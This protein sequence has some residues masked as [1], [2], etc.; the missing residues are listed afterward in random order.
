[1]NKGRVGE[2]RGSKERDRCPLTGILLFDFKLVHV[3]A[4]HHTAADSLSHQL[5]APEDL[6]ET[7]DFE[8]WIDDSY[9]FFM[10]LANWRPPH[11]FPSAVVV[12]NL[13]GSA[14]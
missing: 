10:E 9:S 2:D 11:L 1:M 5:P 12:T 14:R 4:I 8:E 6:P 13:L 3:P 7:N